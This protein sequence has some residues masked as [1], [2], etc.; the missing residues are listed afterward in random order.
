MQ[1]AREKLSREIN[2]IEIVKA[3]RYY[4]NAFRYLLPEKLMFDFKE[5]SR[6]RSVDPDHDFNERKKKETRLRRSMSRRRA[7]MSDGFF[8][9]PSE[10]DSDSGKPAP[11]PKS[12]SR[13]TIQ[14]EEPDD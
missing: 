12:K 9:S 4:D 3:W 11:T 14:R 13:L 8:S 2:I 5:H 6:Y 1:R 7:D 10:G